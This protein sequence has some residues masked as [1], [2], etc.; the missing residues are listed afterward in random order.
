MTTNE[1]NIDAEVAQSFAVV[2]GKGGS[3][4]TMIAVT[5]AQSLAD[6]GYKTL[7]I[8]ADFATGGLS[9]YLT[10]NV[11]SSPKMGLSDISSTK[12]HDYKFEDII[13]GPKTSAI[14][15]DK[16]LELL[17]LITTGDQRTIEPMPVADLYTMISSIFSVVERIFDYIIVD[18][19]GGIDPQSLAV[20]QICDEI[21]VIAETDATSIQSTQ[22]LIDV[23]S[24]NNLK[25]K[26]SGFILNKVMDDPS[27]LAKASIS[28]FRSEYL[29]S[30][31]FDIDATRAYIQGKLPLSNSLFSRHVKSAMSMM[32]TSA[33]S[34]RSI[35]TLSP[36]EFG[37]VTL[38]S[39]EM[40]LGGVMIGTF[41]LY[42]T[43]AVLL[44]Y[45]GLLKLN[46]DYEDILNI[47][48]A[49][50]IFYTSMIF[51]SLSDVLKERIGSIFSA[52]QSILRKIWKM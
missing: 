8:D 40:R 30:I 2:S 9:Y 29:G 35:R 25:K 50:S 42:L 6:L 44:Y 11:F 36:E 43:C 7:L 31:P 27:S 22:H 38:R 49:S 13:T 23:L 47:G 33:V 37:T 46:I 26:I 1:M 21:L 5:M 51:F 28:F 15:D 41:S 32:L 48:V 12:N 18:C 19:R 34:Y 24:K 14:K 17:S 39:P 10:F 4:K 16:N 3:G 45:F 52:Y 20:C